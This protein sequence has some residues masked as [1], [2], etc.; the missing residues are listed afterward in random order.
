MTLYRKRPVVIE[1]Y[2]ATEPL[3]IE[4]LEGTMRANAGDW[5]ITGVNGEEYPCKPDIFEKTYAL[6]D[7]EP[8]E[9]VVFESS[10]LDDTYF[11]RNQAAM[12]LA[13]CAIRLGFRVGVKPDPE[14]PILFIDLPVGQVTWHIPSA[15]LVGEWLDYVGEWDGHTLDE[16]RKRMDDFIATVLD[17][18]EP[19]P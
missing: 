13:R 19:M 17:S 1:A 6:V 15:E 16:K 18:K 12:A 7:D 11:D 8:E 5:I 4:T 3:D 10:T 2:Q 14:W 9:A